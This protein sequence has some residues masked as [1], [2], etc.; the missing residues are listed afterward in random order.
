M[1]ATPGAIWLDVSIIGHLADMG[2]AMAI[3]RSEVRLTTPPI[4]C[5]C[6]QEISLIMARRIGCHGLIHTLLYISAIHLAILIATLYAAPARSPHLKR[7]R[8]WGA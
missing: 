7:Y 2:D 6:A 8:G 3:A 1:H 4:F 5:G